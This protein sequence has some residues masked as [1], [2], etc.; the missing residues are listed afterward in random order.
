MTFRTVFSSTLTDRGIRNIFVK[1]RYRKSIPC[2]KCFRKKIVWVSDKR[3]R[4]RKC[5]SFGSVTKGTWLERS[6]GSLRFWYELVWNFVLC[7]AAHKSSKLM[8]EDVKLCWQGYQVIR[9]ALTQASYRGRKKITGTIE[10]DESFYGGTFKNLRKQVRQELRR[11]GLNK[12][13]G[14]AKYRKQPV[15]GIFKRNGKVYLEPIPEAKAKVLSPLITK[16]IRV[17]SDVFSDTGTWYAGLVGLGYVHKTVDHGKQEYVAGEVHIN[18]L[19]G[20]WGLSKTNMH[21]YKGIKKTNWLLYLKEMEFRYN[22]RKLS[23]DQMVEK[24]IKILM[25]YRR[26]NFVPY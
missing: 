19:E 21:T 2:S 3:F 10:L 13:G 12:R 5:W 6:K 20:F 8:E 15:F 22:N 23:F 7:H 24:I 25:A 1:T 18:G 11:L 17:G 9:K 26:K 16:R 14:G 4:C